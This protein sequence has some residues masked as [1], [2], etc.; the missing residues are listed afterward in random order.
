MTRIYLD[1]ASTTPL[2]DYVKEVLFKSYEDNYGNPSSIHQHGRV[3]R[4]L[5]EQAR[6][7]IANTIKASVGEIFFTSS[8]SE[9]NNMILKRSV[10]DLDVEHFVYSPTEHPCVIKS[11]ETI[12]LEYPH[13]QLTRLDVDHKGNISLDQLKQIL[14]STEDTTMVTLMY[15]NNELGTLHDV[16][17]IG[18]LCL[19]N[20]AYFHSDVVQYIGKRDINVNDTYFSFLTSSAH[21]YH[22]PK[23]VGFFYMNSE[24]IINPYIHGGAQERNMRAGTEN[25]HGIIAMAA[26]LEESINKS[27]ERRAHHQSLKYRFIDRLTHE[28]LDIKIN[29]ETDTEKAMD[30]IV[31]VSFPPTDRV[32]MLMFNLDISGV[33]ASSGSAC[34]SGIESDSPVLIAIGH[35]SDRKT[36]RFSFSH[37]TTS[38]EIDQTIEILKKYT[39]TK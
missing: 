30:H 34:S 17:A 14:E 2:T 29:G 8:A 19:D 10:L 11:L 23:G 1:N 4:S 16:N 27:D 5:I 21:K 31:S 33:S 25:L 28:F 20:Q 6:K 32:D 7:K 22:G 36:I 3:S 35:P 38:D 12:K 24:N 18:R 13:V 9:A 15:A 26:A 39:P 37:L